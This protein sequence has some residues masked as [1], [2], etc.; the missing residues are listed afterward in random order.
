MSSA[1]AL[2]GA[3]RAER[4][5]WLVKVPAAFAAAVAAAAPGAE[6]GHFVPTGSGAGAGAGAGAAGRK[7]TRAQLR[8]Q[9]AAGLGLPSAYALTLD[10]PTGTRLIEAPVWP[11]AAAAAASA[12]TP[13][14]PP[15]AWSLFGLS[16]AAGTLVP[17]ATDAGYEAAVRARRTEQQAVAAGRRA[18]SLAADGEAPTLVDLAQRR[19][20][21]E[22]ARAAAA[23]AA[24]AAAAGAAAATTA[25]AERLRPAASVY[26]CFE[27][28]AYWSVKDLAAATGARDAD[29]RVE[30]QQ[31][32]DYIRA[33]KNVG[34]FRLKPAFRT[35]TSVPPDDNDGVA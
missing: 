30:L 17:D 28:A 20:D 6:L 11:A 35:T 23:S 21:A 13:P 26:D 29:L 33:G 7:R 9:V 3:E 19:A 22:L 5:V 8:L 32:C 2:L 18:T 27:R 10:A 34:T 4:A 15:A 31:T 12:A 24:A 16:C 25:D 14:A 1:P